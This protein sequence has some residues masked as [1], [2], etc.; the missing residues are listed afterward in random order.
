MAT[1][2][3]ARAEYELSKYVH[4]FCCIS[5]AFFTYTSCRYLQLFHG[6]E[7]LLLAGDAALRGSLND[8]VEL[9][10]VRLGIATAP[11]DQ[12]VC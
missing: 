3:P 10:I 5:C 9:T 7:A 6:D 4:T 8:R 11:G 1:L 12:T 2:Q